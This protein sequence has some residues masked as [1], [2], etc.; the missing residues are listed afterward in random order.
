VELYQVVPLERVGRE[1]FDHKNWPVTGLFESFEMDEALLLLAA[2][3]PE[4]WLELE[5]KL[6]REGRERRV[7]VPGTYG[8]T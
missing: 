4:L 1:L 7:P 2:L 6:V 5:I 3:S 8:K